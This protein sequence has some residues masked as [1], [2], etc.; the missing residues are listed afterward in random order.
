[1]PL[2]ELP[3][4]PR[5]RE[6]SEARRFVVAEHSLPDGSLHYDLMLEAGEVLVTLQLE[7]APGPDE[8]RGTRSFDHRL[9][10]LDYEGPISGDRGSVRIWARGS[11]RD[12]QGTPRSEAFRAEFKPEPPAPLSGCFG[13]EAGPE[14][15]SFGPRPEPEA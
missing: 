6:L 11:A 9:R 3:R 12:L 14:G 15:L 7:Q 1:M 4:G 10:Y 8:V 5:G 2:P 13:W